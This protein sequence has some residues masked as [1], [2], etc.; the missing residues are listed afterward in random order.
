MK[1]LKG[2]YKHFADLVSAWERG[3]ADIIIACRGWLGGREGDS[4]VRMEGGVWNGTQCCEDECEG[5]GMPLC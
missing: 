1:V 2:G 5:K 4:D 3:F